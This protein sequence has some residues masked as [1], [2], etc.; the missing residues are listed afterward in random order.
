[1]D[2]SFLSFCLLFGLLALGPRFLAA[3]LT[4]GPAESLCPSWGLNFSGLAWTL[5]R[6][7]ISVQVWR[8]D[9]VMR[10]GEEVGKKWGALRE[11][12]KSKDGPIIWGSESLLEFT[13]V[14]SCWSG[15]NLLFWL[16]W[17]VPKQQ[18]FI[19][20]GVGAW[21]QGWAMGQERAS[22]TSVFW[23]QNQAWEGPN[24]YL[25]LWLACPAPEQP[26]TG[27]S[28]RL[29]L[30]LCNKHL[31]HLLLTN[32]CRNLILWIFHLSQLS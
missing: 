6:Y 10:R 22:G 30:T 26:K 7:D 21:Q 25:L 20:V 8:R 17:S 27:F 19:Y 11:W 13:C 1:M 18:I 5:F 16:L 3:N 23:I 2:A 14:F 29:T 24:M 4:S 31:I 15:L 28:I 32:S 12:R 9:V